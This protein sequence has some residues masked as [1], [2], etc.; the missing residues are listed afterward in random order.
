MAHQ[1]FSISMLSCHWRDVVHTRTCLRI[2]V[3]LSE[4][5]ASVSA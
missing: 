5:F 3:Y 4:G 1:V 2:S